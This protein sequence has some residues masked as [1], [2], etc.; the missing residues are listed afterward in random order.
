V[1]RLW[2]ALGI[3]A[4]AVGSVVAG[5]LQAS[6]RVETV[7]AAGDIATCGG[8]GDARTADVVAG[9]SGTVLTLGNNAYPAGSTA[10]FARCFGPTWGRFKHRIR[11]APG[12]RD[13]RSPDAA[14]YRRY[15]GLSRTY[16]AFDLGAW[17]LYALDSERISTAQLAWLR[18]DLAQHPRRCVLAYWSRPLFNSGVGG[19]Q[20]SVRPFWSVLYRAGAEIVLSGQAPDYERLTRVDPRGYVDYLHG[21]REFVVGTG[22]ARRSSK[23][24]VVTDSRT[25][26]VEWWEPGVL[27][28][29]LGPSGYSWRFLATG[30]PV[31]DFGGESCH[32]KPS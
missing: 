31:P 13:Y 27:R 30:T 18:R 17:R 11:P 8:N 25:R 19:D 5:S 6:P 7:L 28:L 15:F 10:D 9:Q 24:Q 2:I 14:A 29:G 4:V 32:G 22:G 20:P 21:L 16:Y 26:A 3:V 1:R 23:S 12:A